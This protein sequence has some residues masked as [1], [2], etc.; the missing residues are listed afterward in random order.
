M[1]ILDHLDDYRVVAVVLPL[2][3]GNT[4]QLDGVA[5]A[6]TGSHLEVT[7]LQ[8]QLEA[9][10]LDL[11]GACRLSFD[12]GGESKSIKAKITSRPTSARLVLELVET[13]TYQQKR[14][15]FRVDANLSVNYWLIEDDTEPAPN[16]L[17]SSIN[18]SGGG[19]RIPVREKLSAGK[20]IGLEIVIDSPE[21]GVI[22][23]AGEVVNNYS[24][25]N[26]IYAALKFVTIEEEDRD[27][28]VSYCLA[29]Q[30]KQLR[31]KVQV[32]AGMD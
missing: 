17:Q 6:T 31:L 9:Q 21:P 8:G 19:L 28:I 4:A 16:S 5:R 32:L 3:G 2:E 10:A 20:K 26:Q 11:E 7:F 25:G 30:R 18:I 27:L 15:Y 14:Q 24:Q 13:F 29:E 12:V 23:C 22:E 1:S